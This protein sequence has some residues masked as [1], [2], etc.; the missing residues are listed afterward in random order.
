MPAG[1]SSFGLRC[2][3][4]LVLFTPYISIVIGSRHFRTIDDTFGDPAIDGALLTY[5][6]TSA[7]WTQQ[8]GNCGGCKLNPNNTDRIMNGTWHDTTHPA[9]EDAW[10]VK[11]TFTGIA[12]SV[13]CILPPKSAEAVVDYDLSFILDGRPAGTFT[14]T[15]GELTDEYQ[16]NVSVISLDSL[17]NREHTFIMEMAKSPNR[18]VILFDYASYIHDDEG[19]ITEKKK[20]NLGAIFGGLFGA[21]AFLIGTALLLAYSRRRRADVFTAQ[22]AQVFEPFNSPASNMR[23]AKPHVNGRENDEEGSI[24]TRLDSTPSAYYSYNPPSQLDS[25]TKSLPPAYSAA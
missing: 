12:M 16:Y 18:S 4:F 13:F 15:R 19:I 8:P 11:L 14:R 20:P 9:N 25:Y 17:E 24:G 21:L 5:L 6:P 3:P 22:A 2:F 23:L 7:P 10:S 1:R